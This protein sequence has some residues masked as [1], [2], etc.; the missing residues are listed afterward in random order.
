MSPSTPPPPLSTVIQ[1]NNSVFPAVGPENLPQLSTLRLV[2]MASRRSPLIVVMQPTHVWDFPDRANLR[3]LDR[4]W[5]R[6]I[7]RQRPGRMPL[8]VRAKVV[9]QEPPQMALVQDGHVVQ[10]FPADTA[11][12]PLHLS[13][14]P[15]LRGAIRAS[16]IPLWQTRRRK[17]VP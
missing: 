1:Q 16:L 13:V 9:G 12:E 17:S 14:L 7:P 2:P 15:G 11:D 3:P 4:P 5:H 8:M 6:T 10:A